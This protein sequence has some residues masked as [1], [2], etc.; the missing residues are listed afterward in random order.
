MAASVGVKIP[1]RI[2]PRMT[3]T[4]SRDRNALLKECNRARSPHH[5]SFS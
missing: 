1:A 3:T 5:P 4:V 2:P